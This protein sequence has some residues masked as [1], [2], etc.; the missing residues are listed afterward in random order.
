MDSLLSLPHLSSARHH[1]PH[2]FNG[3]VAPAVAEA[4][5]RWLR[6][7]LRTGTV[8]AAHVAK[9]LHAGA[10]AAAQLAASVAGA[11]L[12][13]PDLASMPYTDKPDR[14]VVAATLRWLLRT[15]LVTAREVPAILASPMTLA[16][17]MAEVESRVQTEVAALCCP[18]VPRLAPLWD[19]HV[20]VASNE[21]G[22]EPRT[23]AFLVTV[24]SAPFV[25]LPP[26]SPAFPY[27][28]ARMRAFNKASA[29]LHIEPPGGGA[30]CA[31]G[32]HY[33]E[34]IDDVSE[35]LRTGERLDH[36]IA[37]VTEQ[38]GCSEEVLRELY[39]HEQELVA[40][41]LA[42]GPLTAKED[43][44]LRTIDNLIAT[45]SPDGWKW[46]SCDDAEFLSLPSAVVSSPLLYDLACEQL[47]AEASSIGNECGVLAFP[48]ATAFDSLHRLYREV[49][50]H[51]AVLSH[52]ADLV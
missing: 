48:S 17:R 37:Q 52:V 40:G 6:H 41:R 23:L 28:I 18:D 11:T 3:A 51:N 27:L 43:A 16:E 50:V 10:E 33:E 35:R 5:R 25:V 36:A 42:H 9:A 26:T 29:F 45:L 34:A 7:A 13:A 19:L 31:P 39:E 12:P 24:E 4:S 1:R 15:G 21:D 49:L 30:H 22:G 32:W 38:I 46:M 20:T 14:E 8:A 2:R 47:E 44:I